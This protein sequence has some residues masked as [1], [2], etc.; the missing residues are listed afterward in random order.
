M[1][2][3]LD[4][5]QRIER[6]QHLSECHRW[7][8]ALAELDAALAINPDNALWHAQRGY[9]LEELDR[10]EEASRSYERSLEV[11]GSDADVSLALAVTLVRLGRLARAAEIL[12]TLAQDDPTYE[13]AYCHRIHV[14]AELGRHDK[15]EEVFYLAQ[16]ID[17]S[18]P[19]C[20]FHMGNSLAGRGQFDRAIYC[21]KRAQELD[22][23]Y[24]GIHR[25]MGQAL[26]AKGQPEQAREHLLLELR[27]DPGNTNILYDLADLAWEG[28][29]VVG[30]GAKLAQIIELEP[31]N[32]PAKLMLG[33]IQ[34]QGGKAAEALALFTALGGQSKEGIDPVELGR[35][36][37][38]S[39]LRLGRYP[40]A[41]ERLE[42]ASA[43]RA[44][45]RR[46]ILLLGD[47]NLALRR[48]AA[49]CDCY[50]RLLSLDDRNP[51]VHH[52]LA[53]CL[54]D[55]GQPEV[56]LRHG[57]A[58]IEQ[59]PE[60]VEAMYH[61]ALAHT[62][63]GQWRLCRDLLKRAEQ[64]APDN[65]AVQRLRRDLWRL[66]VRYYLRRFFGLRGRRNPASS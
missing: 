1:N 50:R 33:K 26:R 6:A 12:E 14:Y 45:D 32:A 48:P 29:D 22:P 53:V 66:R 39:L 2:D 44:D 55:L 51:F 34:L 8:E 17:D 28:G 21:W 20:F 31:D 62:R 35:L 15:A 10:D 42:K 56:A 37:G 40:E 27:D 3:W 7:E 64:L 36:I 58:A 24:P 49:A 19:D 60:F 46:A 13:P 16:Q 54:L 30:A 65:V 4:A 9:L 23:D 25:R 59:R 63:L 57:L 38:E 5:E 41:R 11:D 43:A 52:R 18:C 61:T 47:A